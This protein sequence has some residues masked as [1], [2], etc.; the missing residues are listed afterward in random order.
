MDEFDIIQLI[1]TSIFTILTIVSAVYVAKWQNSKEYI[2]NVRP[3]L[4]AAI[5]VNMN[6][7]ASN[8]KRSGYKRLIVN[9]PEYEEV[10]K[11]ASKQMLNA[12]NYNFFRLVNNY[13]SD[14]LNV[15]ISISVNP[16]DKI[17]Y[18]CFRLNRQEE[19]MIF[20]PQDNIG[21]KLCAEIRYS[22]LAGEEF[23]YYF[24]ELKCDKVQHKYVGR[25]KKR[26]TFRQEMCVDKIKRINVN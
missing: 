11:K 14:A 13:E 8:S 3:L 12:K 16:F 23:I 10:R 9:T 22:S 20:L 7:K 18:S 15:N 17:E 19:L 4:Y 1:V 5:Y 2:L 21:S 25:Y 24:S 26:V 6:Y